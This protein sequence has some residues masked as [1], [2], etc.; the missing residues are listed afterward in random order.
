MISLFSGCKG[1]S[2]RGY[3]ADTIVIALS[4]EP[5]RLNPV[6]L[7]DL[8][9]YSVSG[10][11]FNGLTRLDRDMKMT[12]DLAESW[13]IRNAGHEILFRLKKGVFWHDGVEFAADDVV[14]TYKTITSPNTATPHSTNFGSVKEVTALDTYTVRVR[15]S[16]PFGSALESWSIGIIPKHILENRDINDSSFDR[17]PIGTG[18]YKLKE[19]IP[20][21]TLRL[22]A[23]NRHHAGAPNIKGLIIRIIPDTSTQLMEAKKGNIDLM[24]VTPDQYRNDVN[25]AAIA[26]NF[27]KYRAGSF[28]YGFLGFN[29][30]DRRF[31]DKRFR[32]AISHAIDKEAIINTVLW[33]NG[34]PAAGPYPPEAWY[35]SKNALSFEYNPQKAEDI[36]DSLGW[37]RGKNGF[38]QKDGKTLM[39]TI[40]TN[41]ENKERVRIAQLIQSNLKDI[42]VQT[43]IRTL[44]WQAF[45]HNTVSKHQFEAIIL[46]R[47]YLWDPDIY[48]LWHSSK[49][50]EGEWNF[51]SY[52]NKEVDLL[53]QKGRKTLDFAERKRIYNKIHEILAEEQACVFLYNADLLFIANER[54]KGITPSPIGMFHDV[55][56]WY[57]R[58]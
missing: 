20:G 11:I 3:S 15:Y 56:K 8:T 35:A 7:S 57:V 40:L 49:T 39:F 50:K 42:G 27:D 34:S 44:E 38:R 24:E 10:L 18:A 26:S 46:S 19:W 4:S 41:Y 33:G 52:K 48:E 13:E 54:I 43:D 36:L 47:A 16:V 14:F 22:E 30:L 6:F 51:L 28:R 53:L 1:K 2:E 21:Q 9:S 37:I 23:F 5:Q 29:L 31:Q 58:K 55:T 32:Q 17:N 45:R 25:S 12:G